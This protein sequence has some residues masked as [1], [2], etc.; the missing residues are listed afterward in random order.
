V[1]GAVI[2]AMSAQSVVAPAAAALV[3]V[4]IGSFARSRMTGVT[5]APIC[6][7]PKWQST[8]RSSSAA[9]RTAWAV[10]V[11]TVA[12]VVGPL[13]VAIAIAG[14]LLRRQL[15]PM[16][17]ERRRRAAI[18]RAAP[19]RDGP[20]WCRACE[21]GSPRS[22]RCATSP[23]RANPRSA[24]PSARSSGAPN[25]V[26]PLPMR[27]ARCPS[28]S[29]HTRPAAGRRDRHERSPRA[30]ARTGARSAHRRDPGG[31]SPTRPGRCPEASGAPGVPP[32]DL[33][34]AVVRPPRDRARRDRRSV[35]TRRKRLVTV[36]PA[37]QPFHPTSNGSTDAQ[38]PRLMLFVHLHTALTTAPARLRRST[39]RSR[40]SVRAGDHRVCA[41]PAR[42]CTGRPDGGRLGDR[43]RWNGA[44]QPAVQR[45][46]RCRHRQG[47]TAVL[48]R[49]RSSSRWCC[50]SW[51]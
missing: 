47:L 14:V 51:W 11:V 17:A 22:R 43:R 2:S 4:V 35:V 42:R 18:E 19:R 44:H 28:T 26:S 50:R 12:W 23:G 25:G 29:G 24:T 5:R 13:A 8:T 45:R 48:V 46:D 6:A 9:R 40:R 27:W 41:R 21:P 30:A 20:A 32:G 7:L 34:V 15:G 10:G 49:R 33:H 1:I 37:T 36:R 3:A 39:S 31:S 16:R 38:P